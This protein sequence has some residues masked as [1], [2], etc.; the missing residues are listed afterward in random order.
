MTWRRLGVLVRQLPPESAT[1]TALRV[2]T[3]NDPEA[4]EMAAA[5]R[6][7]EAE[8]WSRDQQLLASVRDELHIFRWFYTWAHSDKRPKWDPEPL[9]RPG[10]SAS[11]KKPALDSGQHSMLAAHLAHTQGDNAT[12]N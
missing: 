2:E 9:E 1:A 3:L 11:K 5:V 12:Y 8:Q 4:Q 6:D 10:V 7:V